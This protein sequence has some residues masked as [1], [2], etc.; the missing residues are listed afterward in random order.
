MILTQSQIELENSLRRIL[1]AGVVSCWIPDGYNR[2]KDIIGNNHGQC[3]GTHP[4]VP[5]LPNL[6]DP[7]LGWYFGGDDWVD[8]GNDK[9]LNIIKKVTI[10]AWVRIDSFAAQ[11]V[12]LH[13][14]PSGSS[15]WMPY[16]LIVNTNNTIRF[17][18]GDR[19]SIFSAYSGTLNT[20]QWYRIIGRY[21]GTNIVVFQDGVEQTPTARTG[22][23]IVTTDS[24]KLGY[25]WSLG[26]FFKGYQALP[27]VVK[28]A[29]SQAQIDNDYLNTKSL[30][31]PRG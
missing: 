6:T 1:P 3:D 15:P 2:A 7:S 24:L 23:L 10:G 22:D 21:D 18:A 17:T 11:S 31:W 12:I 27:F 20:H 28:G 19:V 30:F 26:D 4:N 29:W 5:V 25:Q 9:S 8:C 16:G 14:G 13:K